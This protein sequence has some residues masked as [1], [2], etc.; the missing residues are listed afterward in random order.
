L[1]VGLP[2]A[3]N[4]KQAA[5]ARARRKRDVEGHGAGLMTHIMANRHLGLNLWRTDPSRGG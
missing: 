5:Q 2:Q 1:P 3:S 4:G